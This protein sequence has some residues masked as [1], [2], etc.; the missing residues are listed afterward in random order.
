MV[1]KGSIYMEDLENLTPL[2]FD[3]SSDERRSHL[4]FHWI[5]WRYLFLHIH[6][7][8]PI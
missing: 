7:P 6:K 2:D 5:P 4:V 3:I 8:L 1:K